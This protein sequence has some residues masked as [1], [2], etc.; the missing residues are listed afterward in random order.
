MSSVSAA[1][2]VDLAAEKRPG[3][4]SSTSS[5]PVLAEGR[6]S[7]S[8]STESGARSV[9]GA[10]SFTVTSTRSVESL[11][12]LN[13]DPSF[14]DVVE[15]AA[16]L[17]GQYKLLRSKR[18]ATNQQ[19]KEYLF[20]QISKLEAVSGAVVREPGVPQS[21]RVVLERSISKIVEIHKALE[22][23]SAAL[24]RENAELTAVRERALLDVR[25][26][27]A[28]VERLTRELE[29]ARR[30]TAET[31]RPASP[32]IDRGRGA[33]YQAVG[34][35]HSLDDVTRDVATGDARTAL[36]GGK[37]EEKGCC[38]VVM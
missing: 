28:D 21:L 22:A 4:A 3:S 38:C 6:H 11:P 30:A 29:E 25:T 1:T 17:L 31:R 10:S 16:A 2:P 33:S 35:Y 34:G 27:T 8:G 14:D 36:L 26:L 7:R 20:T 37:N 19:V 5:F 32:E 15:Y 23:R 12:V 18:S 24:E 13:A 9:G